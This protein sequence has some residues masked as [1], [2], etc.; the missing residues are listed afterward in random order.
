LEI[1]KARSYDK[2]FYKDLRKL[3]ERINKEGRVPDTY[4]DTLKD[5]RSKLSVLETLPVEKVSKQAVL[6]QQSNRP[7]SG[8]M[9]FINRKS[10]ESN[11]N[12][13][14]NNSLNAIA[15]V[16]SKFAQTASMPSDFSKDNP[17]K[18]V[19]KKKKKQGS[20]QNKNY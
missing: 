18:N 9:D 6:A 17:Y 20:S 16:F 19:L 12:T 14:Q 13:G 10:V 15:S 7:M 5:N 3:E 2:N 11:L 8:K 4:R 1:G